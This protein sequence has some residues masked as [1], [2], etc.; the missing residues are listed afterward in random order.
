[1][2]LKAICSAVLFLAACTPEPDPATTCA[3]RGGEMVMTY[4]GLTCAMPATD[5]GS[6]CTS[7]A[8]CEGLCLADGTCSASDINSGCTP[9]LEDGRVVTLCID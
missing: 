1:M 2:T 6:A 8:Q 4:G 7:S 9:V 5:A 3:A